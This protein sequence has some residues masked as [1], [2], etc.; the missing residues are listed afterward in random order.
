MTFWDFLVLGVILVSGLVGLIRGGTR[1]IVTILSFLLASLGALLALPV[2][3]PLFRRGIDPDW[4]GTVLAILAVFVFLYL[5]IRILGNWASKRLQETTHLGAVDRIFGLSF[6]V[7]RALALVGVFHLVFHA[8]TPPERI[9]G[10]F[11]EA[12]TYPLSAGVAKAIQALLPK[13]GRAVDRLAPHVEGAVRRGAS[14][15]P[16]TDDI[17]AAS[18]GRREAGEQ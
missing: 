15:E 9:P 14:D 12:A 8:A 1:E 17:G 3:G 10:W 2:T 5:L 13:G 4:G 11:R 6:G 18:S 7:V 16:Q